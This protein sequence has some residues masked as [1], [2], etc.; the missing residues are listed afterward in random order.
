MQARKIIKQLIGK[1]MVDGTG[2]TV[3]RARIL[4]V[5]GMVFIIIGVIISVVQVV[6]WINPAFPPA[7]AFDLAIDALV[8]LFGG[9]IVWCVKTERIRYAS[10]S[11]L[12]SIY[13]ISIFQLYAEGQ[14]TK[15]LPSGLGLSLVMALAFVLLDRFS[16]LLVCLITTISFIII[17]ILWLNGLLPQPINRDAISQFTYSIVTWLTLAGINVLLISS[18]MSMLRRHRENLEVMVE[19][20]T[21]E[22]NEAQQHISDVLELNQSII[23]ASSVGIIAY[24]ALGQCVLANESIAGIIG[25]T[26]EQLMEQNLFALESLENKDLLKAAKEA[27][28]TGLETRQEGHIST[29]FSKNIWIDCRFVPFSSDGKP[30][31]LVMVDDVTEQRELREQLERSERLAFLGKMAGGVGHELRNPLAAIKNAVYYL[32]MVFS[33]QEIEPEINDMLNI[34]ETEVGASER[35]INSL[36]NLARPKLPVWSRVNLNETVRETLSRELPSD[37]SNIEVV[38]QL[39]KDIPQILADPDQL[40]QILGNLVRN[41]IQAMKDGGR[42]VVSTA[43]DQPEW[44]VVSVADT[45]EGI[46]EQNCEK[47][48]DPLF[49][50]KAKGIGLGLAIVK[51]LVE[52]H[53]GAISVKSKLGEGSTFTVRL[54]LVVNYNVPDIGG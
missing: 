48:F 1:L 21:K 22:L 45:G 52:R 36:L 19:E 28:S 31:L 20:R 6:L 2:E 33:E 25:A 15:D 5:A 4:M 47:I 23:T 43:I 30:H 38:L 46:P 41:A 49:T 26:H 29:S 10:W 50:T 39:Q 11:V 53:G 16:A 18:T 35:I 12:G 14:P 13:V 7:P 40:I 54:P 34:L 27:L 3:H 44:V 51:T 17:H 37:V 32:S 8:L 24:D 9:L 42:L